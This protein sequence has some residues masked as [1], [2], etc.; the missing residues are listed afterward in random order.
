MND[1]KEYDAAGLY[2]AYPKNWELEESDMGSEAGNL[3]LSNGDG[4]FWMLK[5]YP[6]GTDPEEIAREALTAMRDEYEDMEI[7]RIETG[8]F[9]QS[10]VGFEMTFFY[11]DLMNLAKI[12][13]YEQ[14]GSMHAVFWQTG[15]QLVIADEELVPTDKVLEAITFSLL[16][17][18]TR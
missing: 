15:N 8:L 16:R 9:G 1:F 11:L 14:D 10:L 13:C 12:L 5:K 3:L 4:A 2:F 7:E 6:A 17:G 18:K